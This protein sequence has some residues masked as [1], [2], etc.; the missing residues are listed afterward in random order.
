MIKVHERFT[1]TDRD[2]ECTALVMNAH[3]GISSLWEH[4][5]RSQPET[6][7]HRDRLW[8]HTRRKGM[9]KKIKR[10]RRKSQ[11]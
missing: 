9:S 2:N 5:V 1:R 3:V 4:G 8:G 11:N 7:T 10:R 6:V